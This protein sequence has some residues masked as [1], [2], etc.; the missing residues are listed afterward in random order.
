MPGM[1]ANLSFQIDRREEILK[2]PNAALRF[3]PAK[4]HVRAE[5]K[6]LLEVKEEEL[7]W[8]ED[9]SLST[10]GRSASSSVSWPASMS[11][12]TSDWSRVTCTR[13]SP[14]KI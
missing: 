7:D 1:T 5:D 4:E 13:R 8:N 6:E 9:D 12:L 14:R 10:G 11:W 3:Y 2:V